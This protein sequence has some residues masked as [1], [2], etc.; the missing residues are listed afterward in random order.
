MILLFKQFVQPQISAS[1]NKALHI[2]N[3]PYQYLQLYLTIYYNNNK[4]NHSALFLWHASFKMTVTHKI[5]YIIILLW[6]N[7]STHS[8]RYNILDL[9]IIYPGKHPPSPPPPLYH[10]G[11]PLKHFFLKPGLHRLTNTGNRKEQLKV[12]STRCFRK[13]VASHFEQVLLFSAKRSCNVSQ[14]LNCLQ[15]SGLTC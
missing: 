7:I 8:P 6:W 14:Y 10:S 1:K 15:L 13:K 9:V 2:Y 4:L 3:N 12:S 5:I 11:I